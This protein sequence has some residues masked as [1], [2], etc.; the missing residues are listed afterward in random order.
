MDGWRPATELDA[1]ADGRPA[2]VSL[3]G[4]D[5]FL[6]RLDETVIALANRCTHQGT[7]LHKGVVR[8]TGS[9]RTVQ[10]PAHGSLFSLED[11]R[12]VRGPATQPLPTYDARVVD[13]IVEV[14]PRS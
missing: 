2:R 11:G 9:P 13:G 12:V 14:R 5:L 1:L 10:C 6:L 8:A 7:P 3:D 4:T